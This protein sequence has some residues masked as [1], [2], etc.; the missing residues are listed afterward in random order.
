MRRFLKCWW[1]LIPLLLLPLLFTFSWTGGVEKDLL[2]KSSGWLSGDLSA[3][4]AT[5]FDGQDAYLAGPAALKDKAIA[6]MQNRRG[7]ENVIYTSAVE[8]LAPTTTVA[9][10][11]HRGT[12][13]HRGGHHHGCYNNDQGG[14]DN[15]G[16][17]GSNHHC[18]T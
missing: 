5:K 10:H 13:H 4:K 1:P 3:V 17:P 2:T 15:N 7:V 9:P 8:A 16:S 6:A 12:H 14:G 11:H 18:G